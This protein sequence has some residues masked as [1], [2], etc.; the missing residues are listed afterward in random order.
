M[1]EGS[2]LMRIEM[3]RVLLAG[4]VLAGSV[5]CWATDSPSGSAQ[6]LASAHSGLYVKVQLDN[7]WKASKLKP[8]DVVEGKLARDVYSSNGKL[9]AAGSPVHLT[10][11]R[12][13]KRRRAANDH[14]PGVI[15]LFTPRHENYPVFEIATISAASGESRLQV[16]LISISRRREVHAQARQKTGPQG[17]NVEVNES[18]GAHESE[19]MAAPIVILEAVDESQES[20]S[21]STGGAPDLSGTDTLPAGTACKMLLLTDVSASR[22]KPG[23]VLRARLIEPALL[24]SRVVLQAGTMFEGKVVRK[25]PPRWGSRAGSLALAF[26]GVTQPHGHPVP[27]AASLA[28]AE[29][30]RMSHTRIDPEGQL[31]GDHPGK[32][33]MAINIGVTAGLAKEADDTLQL[34][35]EAVVSTA[36]DASTAGIG[37]IAA[38]AV[39][40]IYMVSR[41]GRDVV[42]PRFTEMDITLDRPL[43][44][45]RNAEPTIS[46]NDN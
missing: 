20:S 31:R 6:G 18:R 14:W 41:R 21:A 3:R 22:S 44:I 9:F 23:D 11:D 15:G 37:R 36:T 46:S 8:G 35:I 7:P 39:S 16:T 32:A 38:G 28:G 13:E 26:T 25:T 2:R 24:N 33:W 45:P 34:I 4:A 10:V 42:L 17:G 30:D 1:A 27:I 29:L 19:K 5:V 43:S 40:G 12:M